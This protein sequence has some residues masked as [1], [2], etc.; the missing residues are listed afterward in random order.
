MKY[1]PIVSFGARVTV[2]LNEDPWKLMV[3]VITV[4]EFRGELTVC[5]RVSSDCLYIGLKLVLSVNT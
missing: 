3:D 2:V 1:K 4:V 5:I